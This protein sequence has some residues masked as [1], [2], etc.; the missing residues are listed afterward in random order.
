MI[1]CENV[2][3]ALHA[4]A[5]LEVDVSVRYLDFFLDDDEELEHIKREYQA[6]RMYTGDVKNRLIKVLTLHGDGCHLIAPHICHAKPHALHYFTMAQRTLGRLQRLI[7]D[8]WL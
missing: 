6:G 2:T 5:N 7:N 8:T 4:G 1:E 3:T